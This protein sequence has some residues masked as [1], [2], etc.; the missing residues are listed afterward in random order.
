MIDQVFAEKSLA[1]Q[2]MMKWCQQWL[3]EENENLQ[4]DIDLLNN[5]GII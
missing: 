3:S 2:S 5:S 4:K 1:S